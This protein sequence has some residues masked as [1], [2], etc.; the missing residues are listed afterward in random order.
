[1]TPLIDVI[2]LLLLFFMLTST[3][4]KY[5]EIELSNATAGGAPSDAP[6]DRSF[7]QLGADRL[8][9]NGAAITLEE[10]AEQVKTG[11]VLIT[12]DP[13]TTAQRLVDL[14]VLL[15]GREGLSVLVLE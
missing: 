9:L 6:Q 14:L 11:Q 5:G 13:D 8:V 1:M 3:F 15:R 4:S 7:V 2:F 12:L 10:L